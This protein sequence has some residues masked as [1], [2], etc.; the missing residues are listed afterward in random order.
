MWKNQKR[1]KN[2]K[3]FLSKNK[4]AMVMP[5]QMGQGSGMLVSMGH[6]ME[7]W[8]AMVV[9]SIAVWYVDQP[10]DGPLCLEPE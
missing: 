5:W 7:T 8:V 10:A 1:K 2:W 3:G 6:K 4:V 9:M